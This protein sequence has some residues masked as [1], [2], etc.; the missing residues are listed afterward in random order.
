MLKRTDFRDANLTQVCWKDAKK[1]DRARVGDSI[2]ADANVRQL[3]ISRS[4]YKQV[5]I[6]ANLEA[7]NL[8]GVNLT[9]AN[10]TISQLPNEPAADQPSLK[11]LLTQLQQAIEAE[12]E[13]PTPDKTDLLEQVQ[14]LTTAKQTT[15][16]AQK[17]GIARKAQKMFEA[18]LKSLPDTAKI[19]EA[20]SKLLPLILKAL[21]L[22]G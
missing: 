7:A 11:D 1:L 5:Y 19:I 18:T 14:A 13:L 9:A 8:R 22:P 6:G 2:L 3:L 12:A 17:A 15:E 21:G 10:L 4:G 16:P 20:S